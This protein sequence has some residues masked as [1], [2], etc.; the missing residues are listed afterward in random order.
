M[1]DNPVWKTILSIAVCLFAVI[2]LAIT[3]SNNSKRSSYSDTSYQN[4]NSLIQHYRNENV[5]NNDLSNDLFYESYDSISKL[6][7][8]EKAIFRVVKVKNDTLLP[9]DLTSK[10]S[11]GPKSFVQ[12]NHDDSLQLAMKLPDNTSIFIHTYSSNDGLTDNLKALK[13]K[14]NIENI[15]VKV[16]DPD[17]KFVSY[18]YQ[19]GGKKYN[20]CALLAKEDG[21]FTSLEFENNK[22]SKEDLQMKAI[23]FVSQ[24]AK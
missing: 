6:N 16:D 21:Q 2:R 14:K 17:S 1:N 7:D 15:K 18:T 11:I 19:Y 22:L 5:Q 12:K 23:T 9:I 20:G 4:V 13:K 24:L 10:I 8:A 3:C